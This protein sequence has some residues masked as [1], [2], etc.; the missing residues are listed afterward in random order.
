MPSSIRH[1]ITGLI[2]AGGASSRMGE[3][4]IDKGL[5]KLGEKPL[6]AHVLNRLKPQVNNI[7]ISANRYLE[8]YQNLGKPVWKDIKYPGWEPF[9][10]PLAGILTGLQN[11]TTP[12]LACVPCDS[13]LVP[14]N[15]VEQLYNNAI[16]SN[17]K[18]AIACTQT[19]NNQQ[20]KD[21]PV[22]ALIHHSLQESLHQYLIGGDRKI[23][24][25]MEQVGFVRVLFDD[26]QAF[27][28]NINTLDD[29]AH[30]QKLIHE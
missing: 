25:W 17:Q 18:I 11:I 7:A 24:L 28:A 6:I 4:T 20:N 22:F 27:I 12:W 23:L 3:K 16:Q 13:P 26:A 30:L 15:L 9:P 5:L 29:L 14:L 1:Q 19:P 21:H 10:G 8:T 2:L